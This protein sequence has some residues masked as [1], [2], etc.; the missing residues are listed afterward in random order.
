[1]T[2]EEM[3]DAI[4]EVLEPNAAYCAEEGDEWVRHAPQPEALEA[5]GFLLSSV[6]L[7]ILTNVLS[8]ELVERLKRRRSAGKNL[9]SADVQQAIEEAASGPEPKPEAQAAAAEAAS[10]VLRA[11][12]WPLP[13]ADKDA[14]MVVVR[15]SVSVWKHDE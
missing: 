5:L 12:G 3:L 11:H 9:E 10:S 4:A 7:P 14:T 15:I 2:S 13:D 1:V 6:V 8:D